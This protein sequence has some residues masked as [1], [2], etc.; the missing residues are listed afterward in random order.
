MNFIRGLVFL[1]LLSAAP[2]SAETK[3]IFLDGGASSTSNYYRYYNEIRR[4]YETVR[5]MGKNAIVHAKDGS[6]KLA[7]NKN[8]TLSD[9]ALTNEARRPSSANSTYPSYPPLSGAV[10]TKEDIIRAISSSNPKSGDTVFIYVSGH[11]GSPTEIHDPSTATISGWN[12]DISFR[13][14]SEAMSQL[15]KGVKI[16]IVAGTCY[17]GGVHYLART[18]PN[19]CTASNT[20]YALMSWSQ[21]QEPSFNKAI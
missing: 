19:V 11:G 13:E 10:R 4:G 15:P 3:Y 20:N 6:W 21:T 8:E 12:N 7:Q 5:S 14:V 17:S 16:K 1:L 2:A 9:L 18:L